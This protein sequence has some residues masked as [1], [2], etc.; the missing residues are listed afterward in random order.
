MATIGLDRLFYAQITECANTGEET[1]GTP[2]MLARA[3]SAELSIELAEATLYADDAA[4]YSLKE[5]KEGK[6]SLGIDD[7]G[8]HAAAILTG[9][10]VDDN[11]VLVSSSEDAGTPVAIAFRAKK[12]NGK[13]RYFWLYRVKFGTPGT[14]LE[15][16]GDSINFQ[17]PTIEG[18]ILRRNRLDGKG[19]HPWKVEA[20]EDG[21]CC[22][23]DTIVNWYQAVYEP[24][25]SVGGRL[26]AGIAFAKEETIDA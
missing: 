15:T 24:C 13:Y 17:T 18:T 8:A 21:E 3:I 10:V 23:S 6:L 12:A 19:E 9:A 2:V 5:F 20:N 25:F 14:N 11:G 22:C 16:K 1:Y 7:I 4:A 26:A